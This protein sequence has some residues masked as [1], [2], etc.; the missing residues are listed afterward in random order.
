MFIQLFG[1]S[2]EIVNELSEN[3]TR[4][5]EGGYRRHVRTWLTIFWTTVRNYAHLWIDNF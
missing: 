3:C 5:N 1:I 2:M 4:K